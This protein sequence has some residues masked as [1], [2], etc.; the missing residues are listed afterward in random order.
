MRKPELELETVIATGQ[1]HDENYVI[2][3]K[4]LAIWALGESLLVADVEEQQYIVKDIIN[5]QAK[6]QLQLFH[7]ETEE[8]LEHI[9]ESSDDVPMMVLD[10]S[11]KL[12]KANTAFVSLFELQETPLTGSR[13]ADIPHPFGRVLI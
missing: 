12:I 5:L 9:F 1:S 3:D 10:G 6:K 8:L 2:N 4:N 7:I 13:L 11:L